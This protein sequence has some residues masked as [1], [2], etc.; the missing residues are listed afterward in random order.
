MRF[1]RYGV[2]LVPEDACPGCYR[3]ERDSRLPFHSSHLIRQ[4][5]VI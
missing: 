4:N 5:S 2:R 1:N 3:T